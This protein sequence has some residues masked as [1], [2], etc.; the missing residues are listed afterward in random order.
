MSIVLDASMTLTWLFEDERTPAAYDVMM[1]VVDEG[2][3]VPSLWRLEVANTLR[4]AIRRGRCDEDF[5]T[6]TLVQ[7]SRMMIKVDEETDQ[8]AWSSTRA[9]SS[10]E[11]LTLYDAAYLELALRAAL[12][13]ATCDRELIAAAERRSMDVLSA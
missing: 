13:L 12:P 6:K 7:L 3:V 2:A 5:V 4:T 9:L 1:R 10:E 11:G 8:H